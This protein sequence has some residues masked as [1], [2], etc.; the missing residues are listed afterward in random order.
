VIEGTFATMC[1]LHDEGRDHI[2]A[3][4]IR[5]LARPMW[6][7]RQPNRVDL[8]IG[9]PP[10]LAYRHMTSDMQNTFRSMSDARGLWH[11]AEMATQQDLSA[12]FV[13]RSIQLY[14]KSGG[15]FAF[16]MPNA[17]VD[18]AQYSGFRSG[19]YADA[20]EILTIAFDVPWDLRR[21]RPHFFPRGACVVFGSRVSEPAAMGTKVV[22]WAGR[23]A[24]QGTSWRDVGPHLSQEPGILSRVSQMAS[25]P[26]KDRF[27]NGATI[28]PRLLFIVEEQQRSPIGLPAGKMRVRSVRSGNEKP[29]WKNLPALEGVVETEFVRPVILSECLLPFRLTEPAKGIIPWDSTRLLGADGDDIEMYP[30]LAEWW[31][32]ASACWEKNRATERLSLLDRLNYMSNMVRQFPSASIRIV[33]NKSGMH[34]VAAKVTDQ[35]AVIENGLYWAAAASDEEADYLCAVLNAPATTELA[36]PFM[37]YGKDERDMHK[38]IWQLPIPE[39]DYNSETHKLLAKLGHEAQAL[40]DAISIDETLHFSATRRRLR[41]NLELTAPMQQINEIVFGMLS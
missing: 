5:N 19:S 4:Y 41:E 24:R 40:M 2:W 7:A 6:L 16:V 17:A 34:V 30:G 27:S 13:T 18:R 10:W 9:N 22:N 38:H 26:Y 3:Y 35:R 36:R 21:I 31:A 11:G 12:L 32:R 23:I 29:P 14:L 37:S 25:S 1:R 28:F 20:S 15:R 8:L 33:Y 39:F